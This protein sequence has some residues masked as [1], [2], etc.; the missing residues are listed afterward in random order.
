MGQG[1]S[2]KRIARFSGG[3]TARFPPTN[4]AG[5]WNRQAPGFG[6]RSEIIQT[7]VVMAFFIFLIAVATVVVLTIALRRQAIRSAW[8]T[9]AARLG[10]RFEG[11]TFFQH[12]SIFGQRKGFRI[13]VRTFPRRAGAKVETWTGYRVSF[14][15]PTLAHLG[16]TRLQSLYLR[17]SETIQNSESTRQSLQRRAASGN[18]DRSS[19][20]TNLPDSR[21]IRTLALDGNRSKNR[22]R[23]R[24][25]AP[26]AAKETNARRRVPG[27]SAPFEPDGAAAIPEPD[28]NP[29]CRAEP[30]PRLSNLRRPARPRT[31]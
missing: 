19:W 5:F 6:V 28:Q 31:H 1:E 25:L 3:G 29:G 11:G 12:L 9:A 4:T 7:E 8:D 14:P 23:R 2:R 27:R 21:A 13:D 15:E 18:R 10:L 20:R 26:S 17:V 16:R 30:E 22:L 24:P